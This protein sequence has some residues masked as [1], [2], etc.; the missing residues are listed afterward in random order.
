M[1]H[2]KVLPRQ[3]F[4]KLAR[5]GIIL[6]VVTSERIQLLKQ[7]A[8]PGL[9]TGTQFPPEVYVQFRETAYMDNW[10]FLGT[11]RFKFSYL[12]SCQYIFIYCL[13]NHYIQI[14]D[15][16]QISVA[17]LFQNYRLRNGKCQIQITPIIRT[18]KLTE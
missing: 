10:L 4:S 9:W 13:Y 16:G 1:S 12:L 7:Y 15:L 5:W 3:L 6:N 2:N 17:F 14:Y 11:G 18:T 8:S